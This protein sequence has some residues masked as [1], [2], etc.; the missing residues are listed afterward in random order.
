MRGFVIIRASV[1]FSFYLLIFCVSSGGISSSAFAERVIPPGR[2]YVG[3]PPFLVSQEDLQ[4]HSAFSAWES[5][6][7]SRTSDFELYDKVKDMIQNAR[8]HIVMSMFLFDCMSSNQKPPFDMVNE[9]TELIIQKKRANPD[10]TIAIILDS[11]NRAYADRTSPAVRKLLENGIDIFYSD[12]METSSASYLR[13]FEGMREAGRRASYLSFKVLGAM[14]SWVLSLPIPFL[15]WDGG[16]IAFKTIANALLLK[17]NHRKILVTDVKGENFEALIGSANIH[18]PSLRSVN[19]AVSVKGEIAKYIY[20]VIRSDV[21]QSIRLGQDYVQWAKR[22]K[23]EPFSIPQFV[24]ER[25]PTLKSHRS[26]QEP[27][28]DSK[29]SVQFLTESKIKERI[30]DMLNRAGPGDEV[31]IQMFYLSH[32]AVLDAILEA[33]QRTDQPVRIILDP[34]KDVLSYKKDGTPNRQVAVYLMEEMQRNNADSTK[35]PIRLDIRWYRTGGFQMHAKIMSVTNSKTGKHE[36]ITGSANWTRKNLDDINME[37]N[38]AMANAPLVTAQFNSLFDLFW[39]GGMGRSYT[40]AYDNEEFGY[41]KA[42]RRSKWVRA[43]I[44]NKV[45]GILGL[46]KSQRIQDRWRERSIVGW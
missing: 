15:K 31:R 25:L 21:I 30:I 37:S 9:V 38:I 19:F 16:A 7:G 43:R 36:L 40:I 2:L 34:N 10:M 28:D 17:G 6:N 22:P 13:L 4:L 5:F 27:A 39:S 41:N 12:L 35:K 45:L 46:Q 20:S 3:S 11:I 23:G 44:C 1:I 14:A 8:S 24:R 42:S 29:A 32:L 33:S 26:A 18:N